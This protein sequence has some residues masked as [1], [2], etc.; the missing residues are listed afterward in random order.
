MTKGPPRT[1][2]SRN[3]LP[4]INRKRQP[5]SPALTV[6]QIQV[7]AARVQRPPVPGDL[8]LRIAVLPDGKDPADVLADDGAEVL[9]AAVPGGRI[10]V[11]GPAADAGSLE[12]SG[13]AWRRTRVL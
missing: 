7:R 5:L 8:D 6:K 12:A 1:T 10:A 11:M 2:A 3:G 13:G 9:G 4:L